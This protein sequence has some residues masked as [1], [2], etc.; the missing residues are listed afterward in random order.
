MPSPFVVAAIGV[1]A[2]GFFSVAGRQFR[3]YGTGQ[4]SYVSVLEGRW[5]LAAIVIAVAS[6]TSSALLTFL[7][8]GSA[9]TFWTILGGFALFAVV[10]SSWCMVRSRR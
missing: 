10:I 2:A 6:V 8:D 7:T 5:W 1:A 4:P 3:A 9:R